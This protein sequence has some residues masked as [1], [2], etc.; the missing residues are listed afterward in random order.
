MWISEIVERTILTTMAGVNIGGVPIVMRASRVD[1]DPQAATER[2]EYPCMVIMAAGGT[3][4]TIES[5]F[6]DVNC[7]VTLMTNYKDDA[8][9]TNLA[10]LEDQMRK[11]LDVKIANTPILPAFNSISSGAGESASFKGLVEI[12]GFPVERFDNVQQITTTM[13]FKTCGA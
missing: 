5:L 7:T 3:K 2:R 8:K 1:D 13:K 12:E 9:G 6:H 11:I 10:S 4:S